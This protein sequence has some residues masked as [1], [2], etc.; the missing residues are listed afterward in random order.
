MAVKI[1]N[2]CISCNSC[3]KECPE[4]AIVNNFD[5]PN[6]ESIYYVYENKCTECNEYGEPLC[7]IVCPTGCIKFFTKSE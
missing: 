3:L 1:T 6:K 7:M 2:T 4:N 5:N